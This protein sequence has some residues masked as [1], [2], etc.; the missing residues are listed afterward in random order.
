M[1]LDHRAHLAIGD[2]VA[3]YCDAVA[4]ADLDA[5]RACWTDDAR[6]TGPGLD[7][8][9]VDAIA[10]TFAASR[11]RFATAVQAIL[12]GSVQVVDH[13][14]ATGAWWI[15]ET[16]VTV[17]GATRF[18]TGRYDDEYVRRG[19]GWQFTSRAF[20]AVRMPR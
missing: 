15:R 1:D 14:R 18:T 9:G 19:D 16:L 17:D 13:E 8:R 20:T 12:S 5:F 2:L 10:S 7:R 3:R 4:R 11:A 6:W